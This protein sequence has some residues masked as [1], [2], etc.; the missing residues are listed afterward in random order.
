MQTQIKIAQ[1]YSLPE[2]GLTQVCAMVD[3]VPHSLSQRRSMHVTIHVSSTCGNVH[4]RQSLLSKPIYPS[5]TC[6]LSYTCLPFLPSSPPPTPYPSLLAHLATSGQDQHPGLCN[7]VP[8]DHGGPIQQLHPRHG[9][10]HGV[11]HRHRAWHPP[12]WRARPFGGS[13][14]PALRL[15]AGQGE[16]TPSHTHAPG[17]CC[18]LLGRVPA[19]TCCWLSVQRWALDV[20]LGASFFTLWLGVRSS[21]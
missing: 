20:G 3:A 17:P 8:C 4:L 13:R 15:P 11:P 21:R 9:P 16:R 7:A 5:F 10:H 6:Y 2:L 12:G 1:G 19:T 18:R 14:V